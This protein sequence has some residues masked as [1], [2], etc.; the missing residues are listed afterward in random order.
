M[1]DVPFWLKSTDTVNSTDN[2]N[3]NIN[4]YVS[5]EEEEEVQDPQRGYWSCI[6][7]VKRDG[8]L[9]II[10]LLIIICINIPFLKWVVYPF[11]IFSTYIHEV[12][13][14]LAA[15]FIGGHVDKI[16]MYPD[17]SGL[18]YSS[19][20]GGKGRSFVASAGYQGTALIGC[21]LL[22][23]RRTKRG[24]RLGTLALASFMILSVALW[25]RNLFGI[26]ALSLM[27]AFLGLGAWKLP[28]ARIRDLY[29]SIAIMTALNAITSVQTL[30]GSNF[31][32]NGQESSTDAHTMAEYAGGS[33]FLWATVWLSSAIFLT[34]FGLVFAIPGPGEGSFFQCCGICCN[35]CRNKPQ[36]ATEADQISFI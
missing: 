8:R 31:V 27:A 33:R 36:Q 18:T 23:L 13:H 30:Y 28:S 12:C 21:L 2:I 10:T 26:I 35:C 20:P 32:V 7:F 9:L 14:G 29:M 5:E 11:T 15:V 19:L 6:A 1:S 34:I 17:G 25:I 16:M 3:N 24:P 4:N 22:I